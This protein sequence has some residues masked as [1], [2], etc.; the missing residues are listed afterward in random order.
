[1]TQIV[2]LITLQQGPR[3]MCVH[4]G[5]SGIILP[6]GLA[7]D[8][9]LSEIALQMLAYHPD[10]THLRIVLSLLVTHRPDVAPL[11]DRIQTKAETRCQIGDLHQRKLTSR[12]PR[13]QFA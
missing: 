5:L 8:V 4:R 3:H 7:S 9:M 6:E 2:G 12:P 11:Y 10:E 13:A 1:M